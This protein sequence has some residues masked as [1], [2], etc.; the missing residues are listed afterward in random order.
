MDNKEVS[1]K[2][3]KCSLRKCFDT[4]HDVYP[5]LLP[6]HLTSIGPGL[7]SPAVLLFNITIRCL[8]PKISRPPYYSIMMMVI[9]CLN[10]KATNIDKKKDTCQS[11]PFLHTRSPAA[12]HRG[13]DSPWTHGN[14]SWTWLQT[15]Q[16]QILQDKSDL[17]GMY[18]QN[19]VWSLPP[20]GQKTT[21]MMTSAR[22]KQHRG[23]TN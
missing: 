17:N 12:V 7:L 14:D 20:S 1:L 15:P 6:I 5:V 16:Y 18:N 21:H 3:I 11:S 23:T 19:D 4:D 10:R 2:L 22:G 8:M 13:D 9:P